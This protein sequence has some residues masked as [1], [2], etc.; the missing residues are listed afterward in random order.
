MRCGELWGLHSFRHDTNFI[1]GT[2]CRILEIQRW[3]LFSKD[4]QRWRMSARLAWTV[5]RPCRPST[6]PA[7]VSPSAVEYGSASAASVVTSDFVTIWPVGNNLT[8][9]AGVGWGILG[10]GNMLL[11]AFVEAHPEVRT[12]HRRLS[13]YV[14]LVVWRPDFSDVSKSHGSLA[15]RGRGRVHPVREPVCEDN[16]GLAMAMRHPWIQ[17]RERV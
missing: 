15:S 2:W 9:E 11:N 10:G 8:P 4:M 16:W 1:D 6:L 3:S 5:I 14:E 7:S 17:T 13:L 12:H